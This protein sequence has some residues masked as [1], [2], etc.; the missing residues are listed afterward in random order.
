M[1]YLTAVRVAETRFLMSYAKT[2]GCYL[3]VGT[4]NDDDYEDDNKKISFGKAVK[5]A[6]CPETLI[7]LTD[8]LYVGANY[9]DF[10][11][12]TV[13]NNSD[14]ITIGSIVSFSF[15][16]VDSLIAPLTGDTFA[17]TYYDDSFGDNFSN[18]TTAVA[19]VQGAD[20]NIT[21][22]D[23]EKFS[24]DRNTHELA[25]L[26][27]SQYLSCY[28]MAIFPQASGP[29]G[30][31][32]FNY[33]AENKDVFPVSQA[34]YPPSML[35]LFFGMTGLS[36]T[37]AAVVWID[38]VEQTNH[39]LMAVIVEVQ[40]NSLVFGSSMVL[41][42]GDASG[43]LNSDL[44][45]EMTVLA[46]SST[47]FAVLYSDF[48]NQGL[49]TLTIVDVNEADILTAPS[50]SF[51]TVALAS[52]L[53]KAETDYYWL[54]MTV[55]SPTVFVI[56]DSLNSLGGIHIGEVLN[57]AV[58]VTTSKKIDNLVEVAV[59]GIATLQNTTLVPGK[60]SL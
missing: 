34:S 24:P 18:L 42:S 60:S 40:G 51:S 41:N 35:S 55:Q 48:A 59:G 10:L 39:R 15:I 31:T 12:F 20:Y 46:I 22:L 13:N 53:N 25:A 8:E 7:S 17:I 49:V 26:S 32:L 19:V 1:S 14:T 5:N 6:V 4:I 37:Q 28:P 56:Y 21:I 27:S 50:T 30:C 58:G 33:S 9:G 47:Q 29:L 43:V 45:P 3:V 23:T 2:G 16:G 36:P 38:H 11:T 57:T 54:A 44:Y 52:P